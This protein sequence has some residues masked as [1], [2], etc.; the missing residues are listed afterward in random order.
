[1]FH[2]IPTVKDEGTKYLHIEYRAVSVVFR[3]ID[4]QPPLPL[5]SVSSSPR[6][7]GWG[8]H[9][10]GSEG[11][12]VNISKDAWHWIGLLQY[13]PSTDGGVWVA[14]CI[15]LFYT[16]EGLSAGWADRYRRNSKIYTIRWKHHVLYRITVCKCVDNTVCCQPFSRFFS[17]IR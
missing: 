17:R 12:G 10:P 4:P 2:W 11:V 8:T 13:N 1:M 16:S 9:S 5:A 15:I 3:T 6:T 7:K 14:S